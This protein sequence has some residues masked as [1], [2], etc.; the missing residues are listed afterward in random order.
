[1]TLETGDKTAL[2]VQFAMIANFQNKQADKYRAVVARVSQQYKVSPSLA[3]AVIKVESNFNPFAVSPA[4]AYG[5][6]QLVPT[7]GGREAYRR[8]KGVDGVPTREYLFD[9]ENNI[10]L[11]TAYLGV[12]THEQLAGVANPVAREYCVI[13]GYNTG[14]GN[15]MKAFAKD[16][17][18]ALNAVN[19]MQPPAVYER[20]RTQLPYQETRQYVVKVVQARKQFVSRVPDGN[21][22]AG[23]GLVTP[24]GAVPP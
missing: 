20:L 15:V 16:R 1:V 24:P 13:A 5:M 2:H 17:A 6:M 11:G 18:T 7:S 12:L 3:L 22:A 9:A 8:V 19:G 23:T 21:Q 4:P 10:E 14:P